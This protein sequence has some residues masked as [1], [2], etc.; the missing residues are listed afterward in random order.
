VNSLPYKDDIEYY[1]KSVHSKKLTCSKQ[2]FDCLLSV[3]GEGN[4]YLGPRDKQTQ[5]PAVS[6]TQKIIW[7]QETRGTVACWHSWF[8]ISEVIDCISCPG[9]TK[10]T[11]I[12]AGDY[13]QEGI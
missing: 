4:R 7:S 12:P 9:S 3:W 5:W 8:G 10:R 13:W 6:N 1:N 11:Y 2:N